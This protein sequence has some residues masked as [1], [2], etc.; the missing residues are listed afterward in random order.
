MFNIPR[1]EDELAKL[2]RDM[3]IAG[4]D[5]DLGTDLVIVEID[6][7][8]VEVRVAAILSGD[9]E[10]VAAFRSGMDFHLHT[11]KLI[12]PMVGIDP[13][14]VTKAHPLRSKAKTIVFAFLYG[15]TDEGIAAELGIEVKEAAKLRAAIL[16]KYKALAAWLQRMLRRGRLT[17]EIRTQWRGLDARVRPLWEIGYP[18]GDSKDSAEN[19]TANT[20]IQGTAA[21]F[22]N[23]SLGHIQRWIED[24]F[25]PAKL[26][27]TV[28]DSIMLRCPRS[29]VPEVAA[30]VTRI[31][32]QWHPLL[33]VDVKYGWS[34]GSL[35]SWKP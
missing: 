4:V 33:A 22:T 30:N 24:D 16:G 2:C 26:C 17:G 11:A 6:Q 5:L 8:Q 10:M 27:L 23:A 21:D 35:E 20:P 32:T 31:C 15:K 18:E 14:L 13:L 3:F 29:A 9:E 12:A 34:W 19:S 1:P 7:S 28:Y 25:V